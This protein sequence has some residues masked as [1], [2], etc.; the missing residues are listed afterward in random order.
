MKLSLRPTGYTYSGL[1]SE[2]KTVY[3]Y[4]VVPF[5]PGSETDIANFGGSNH[6]D[7]RI[8]RVKD[9][10]IGDWVGNFATAE[11]ALAAIQADNG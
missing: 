4:G 1:G 8:F 3:R 10:L 6:A 9:G 2:G 11:E 5:V 7:W